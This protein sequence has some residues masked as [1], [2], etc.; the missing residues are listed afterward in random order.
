M[1]YPGDEQMEKGTIIV[2]NGSI[3]KEYVVWPEDKSVIEND[4]CDI[5]DDSYIVTFGACD[6]DD[7]FIFILQND[8]DDAN[9]TL[10]EA[11]K[12]K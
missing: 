1:H 10:L 2:D 7:S 8:D 11:K 12:L 9:P 3:V 6:S 5:A 4:I